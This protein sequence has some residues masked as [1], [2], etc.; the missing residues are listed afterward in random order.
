MVDVITGKWQLLSDSI[1]PPLSDALATYESSH[2]L[3]VL[4]RAKTYVS[5][6]NL[7]DASEG[8]SCD[9]EVISDLMRF[10]ALLGKELASR[11]QV[12]KMFQ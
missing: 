6:S 8:Y 5:L 12:D 9:D 1:S 11:C 4:V 10:E 3:R 2:P 7:L